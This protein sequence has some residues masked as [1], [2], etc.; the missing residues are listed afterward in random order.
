MRDANFVAV[1]P[2]VCRSKKDRVGLEVPR[3]MNM[4]TS[5]FWAVMPCSSEKT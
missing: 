1:L 4:K 2:K 3:A 5:I